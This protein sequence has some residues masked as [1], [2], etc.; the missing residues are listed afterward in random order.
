MCITLRVCDPCPPP[1]ALLS[2]ALNIPVLFAT[3]MVRKTS[4]RGKHAK[5]T[6]QNWTNHAGWSLG[7]QSPGW[8]LRGRHEHLP[9]AL[10]NNWVRLHVVQ[11]RSGLVS[12]SE[13]EGRCSEAAVGF[14]PLGCASG[15]S[16]PHCDAP[17]WGWT[18]NWKRGW[19]L[20]DV[21]ATHC[22]L[23]LWK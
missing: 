13:G 9:P 21:F 14:Q 19:E 11:T 5:N 1:G 17:F 7:T 4:M 2:T 15:L 8:M 10:E 16:L 18:G 22:A 3:L 20:L 12:P 6:T 23:C